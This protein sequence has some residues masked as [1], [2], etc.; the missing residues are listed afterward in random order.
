M[1][2]V[3]LG[4]KFHDLVDAVAST[5]P[6]KSLRDSQCKRGKLKRVF[7]LIE[8]SILYYWEKTTLYLLLIILKVE[9]VLSILG[10]R[11][12]AAVQV[13]VSALG[14]FR[15][16]KSIKLHFFHVI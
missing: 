1:K 8:T 16:A 12:W 13:E 6:K 3:Y 14:S 15:L 5:I 2:F 11:E 9:G 10:N 4:L 7:L